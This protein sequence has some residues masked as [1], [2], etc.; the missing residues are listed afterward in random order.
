VAQVIGRYYSIDDDAL[1]RTWPV[2][3]GGMVRKAAEAGMN[4]ALNC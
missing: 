1:Y 2:T 4:D 3:V